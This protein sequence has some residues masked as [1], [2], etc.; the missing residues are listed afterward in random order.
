MAMIAGIRL[1][2]IIGQMPLISCALRMSLLFFEYAGH[3]HAHVAFC[4]PADTL[5]AYFRFRH[6]RRADTL[7]L[8]IRSPFAIIIFSPAL[9]P[10][11]T[12]L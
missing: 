4:R 5:A 7:L 11:L 1:L 10:S 9:T 3:F 6:A 2:P 8:P 12:S